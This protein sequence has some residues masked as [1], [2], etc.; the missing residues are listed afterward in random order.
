MKRNLD[1]RTVVPAAFDCSFGV[2]NGQ[3]NE[4]IQGYEHFM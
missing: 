3:S 2:V 4:L 1:Y